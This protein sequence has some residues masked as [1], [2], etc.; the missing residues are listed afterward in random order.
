MLGSR[1]RVWYFWE[2]IGQGLGFRVVGPR[3][4][5]YITFTTSIIHGRE[6]ITRVTIPLPI[7]A[8]LITREIEE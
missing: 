4:C 8:R 3:Q 6:R 7:T 1:F 5:F 2:P